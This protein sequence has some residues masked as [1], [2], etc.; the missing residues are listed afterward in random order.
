MST[1]QEQD[2]RMRCLEMACRQPFHGGA[3]DVIATAQKMYDFAM[4][5][6]KPGDEAKMAA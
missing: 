2:L 4:N 6:P 5:M 3:E 1:E